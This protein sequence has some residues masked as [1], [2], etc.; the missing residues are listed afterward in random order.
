MGTYLPSP[1]KTITK[2]SHNKIVNNI[3]RAWKKGATQE[4]SDAGEKQRG[5]EATR[6]CNRPVSQQRNGERKNA[7]IFTPFCTNAYVHVRICLYLHA[8]EEVHAG[9]KLATV[10]FAWL[11][12]PAISAKF[13]TEQIRTF[14]PRL[15]FLYFL[16][17]KKEERRI[18]SERDRYVDGN[19]QNTGWLEGWTTGRR[20]SAVF[21][22]SSL[23]RKN[24][25]IF[26]PHQNV[27]N[28]L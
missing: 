8:H 16:F 9:K 7:R 1:C 17:L 21:P 12:V 14:Y 18:C 15:H 3:A 24:M 25:S 11:Q 23:L 13:Y 2:D 5:E 4:R 26:I 28:G 27:R 19:K 20:K 22:I 6:K 10:I